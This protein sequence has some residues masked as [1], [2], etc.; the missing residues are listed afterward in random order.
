MTKTT[1]CVKSH[2]PESALDL[3]FLLLLIQLNLLI[4]LWPF[5]LQEHKHSTYLNTRQ[6][7]TRPKG[8]SCAATFMVQHISV[9][10]WS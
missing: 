3:L 10:R 1:N 7:H 8:S 4:K 9:R 6:S 5:I 2:V